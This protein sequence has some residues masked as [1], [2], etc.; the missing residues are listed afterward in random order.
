MHGAKA[1]LF[2]RLPLCNA[3]VLFIFDRKARRGQCL[4]IGLCIKGVSVD[5]RG[6]NGEYVMTTGDSATSQHAAPHITLTPLT[7]AAVGKAR[8][9]YLVCVFHQLI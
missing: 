1:N 2:S 4:T 3:S 6:W 9:S 5:P 8:D 7:V